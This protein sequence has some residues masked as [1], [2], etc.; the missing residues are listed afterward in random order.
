MLCLG[1]AFRTLKFASKELYRCPFS[2][3]SSDY[4]YKL[5]SITMTTRHIYLEKYGPVQCSFY[6]EQGNT[7]SF[8]LNDRWLVIIMATFIIGSLEFD[9]IEY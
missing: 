8:S 7:L 6:D 1:N 5:L 3:C 4:T 2:H 9:C